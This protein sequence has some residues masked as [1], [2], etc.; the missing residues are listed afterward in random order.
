MS[1]VAASSAVLSRRRLRSVPTQACPVVPLE[2]GKPLQL[3]K[4][5]RARLLAAVR[6][7]VTSPALA[8]ASDGARL[9]SVVLTAKAKVR[10]DYQ[11]KI[12]AAELGRWLGVSQSTVAHTVLP[13]LRTAGFLGSNVAT[14]AFGHATGL[15]CW[16][17]PMYRAQK[18]GDRRHALA[19]S[20]SELAVLLSLIE[21]LFGPGW[22]PK[23]KEPVP[24]GLLAGR[25]GRGAATD[26]LGLLLMVLTTGS[27]G[28]LQLC[29]GSVDTS[30]GRP[31][32]TVARLLG[33]TAAAG[34]KVLK[35]LQEHGV[36]DVVRKETGSGLNAQSRVRLVPVA[37]AHGVAV[38]EARRVADA[39]FSDLAGTASRDLESGETGETLVATGMEGA[40]QDG[41]AG[42]ADL[43][44][45]AQHHA[46]HASVVTSAGSLVLAGGFS[47]EGR[48]GNHGLPDRACLRED[49]GPLRGE[50]PKE[51]PVDE[52]DGQRAAGAGGRPK[53]P[54]W[55]K[56]Q[57]QRRVSLPADL[58][59]R[60]ALGPVAW[61]WERLSGWQQDQVEAAVKAELAQLAGLGVAPEGAPRLLADRLTDRLE[62]T[63]G[64]ARVHKP[65]PWLI[66]R[67][68][69]QR[70]ACSHHKCDD[71]VRLDTGEDCENC[72]NVIH[73][74]R[75]RRARICA[76][77][78][79]ELPGLSDGERRRVL[80]ERL[81]EQAA[82]EAEDLVWRREQ[83]RAQQARRDAARAA[84]AQRAEAE[85][86]TAA[87]ADAVRQALPC[88]DCGRAQA[89]GLCEVCDHRR[90]TEALIGEA[91]LLTAVWS[92]DLADPGNVAAVAA[93]A[94]TTIG[95]SVATVWQEFLEIT[96]IAVLEADPEA[97]Q[98]AYAFAALQTAQQAV[99][100][101][102]D[103]AL[104]ML[105]RTE[106]AEAEARRAY[107]TEQGRHWFKHNPNGADA[108]AAATRAADTARERVAKY[109]LATRLEQ[110]RGLAPRTA[111]A[112]IA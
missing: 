30:R 39:V 86:A 100:D 59:L 106:E 54:G 55:E 88:G 21:V 22:A 64:E 99:Q 80:E 90:Q 76:D 9:A 40:G 65:F 58:R 72:G 53:G 102:Q 13:E 79:R 70:R 12:W 82:I 37:K 85:R 25:T 18:A 16:V 35:R 57:Q 108:I 111:G 33:C 91:G 74:R 101:H 94:R 46:L 78:D 56:A 31:A 11:A 1:A 98:D 104:A 24:A 81:G 52:R 50:Q 51:F 95:H 45:T 68:L 34:A 26:R 19:L 61:L 7:L 97:A 3:S 44:T 109:L 69:P 75:A 71:G 63:G 87:A 84:A 47:G 110:L 5:M 49:G 112:V 89:A 105:G 17:I 2:L 41:I 32:A 23:D 43:A 6:A 107:K 48:R 38:R 28:W 93:G 66:R 29:P 60:V 42:L 73:L 27:A 14:N 4:T 10:N 103:T 36:A 62:E 92:A 8:G 77:I 20:R 67:G 15:E 83:A 96:D